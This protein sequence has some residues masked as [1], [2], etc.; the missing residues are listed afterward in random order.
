MQNGIQDHFQEFQV[1]LNTLPQI[2][3]PEQKDESLHAN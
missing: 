1:A 3:Q 2:D